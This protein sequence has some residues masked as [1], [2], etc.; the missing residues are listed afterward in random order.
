[1]LTASNLPAEES[2][3]LELLQLYFA[4]VY[5]IKYLMKS[6]KSLKGGLQ[7]V[8]EIMEVWFF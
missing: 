1:M 7:E 2:E 6:C 5:D 4:R 8:A 3:F